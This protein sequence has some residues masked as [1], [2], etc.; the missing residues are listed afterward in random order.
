M[1]ALRDRASTALAEE[2]EAVRDCLLDGQLE[3]PIA[4]V[5]DKWRLLPAFLRVR[6]LVKQH[7]DS[8]NHLVL[9][10]IHI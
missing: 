8:Y 4:E 10:L 3:A 1:Q 5:K 9:S 7:L 6:G 2:E